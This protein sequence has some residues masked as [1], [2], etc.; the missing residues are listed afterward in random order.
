MRPQLFACAALI[1]SL[2]SNLQAPPSVVVDIAPLHSLVSQVMEDVA[3]PKL[4]IP[5]EIETRLA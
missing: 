1:F 4:I 2:S 5:A 3:K